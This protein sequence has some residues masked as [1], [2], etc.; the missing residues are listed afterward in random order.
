MTI[1]HGSI[2]GFRMARTAVKRDR[3][4]NEHR[5]IRLAEA[6]K[7]IDTFVANALHR[8]LARIM[9]DSATEY[10]VRPSTEPTSRPQRKV[11]NVG[12]IDHAKSQLPIISKEEARAIGRRETLLHFGQDP[13]Q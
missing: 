12:R 13:D 4:T 8:G 10:G 2:S 7:L 3:S 9:R 6:R 5:A 11:F 1:R